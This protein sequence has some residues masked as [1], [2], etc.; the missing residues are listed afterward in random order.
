M[1][2]FNVITFAIAVLGAILGVINMWHAIDK[3]TGK[4]RV[5]L[6]HAIPVGGMDE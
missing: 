6:K 5:I 1:T 4:L 3:S 2:I